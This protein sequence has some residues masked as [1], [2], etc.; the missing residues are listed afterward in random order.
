MR[1]DKSLENADA[2]AFGFDAS[3]PPSYRYR[4]QPRPEPLPARLPAEELFEIADILDRERLTPNSEPIR[5]AASQCKAGIRNDGAREYW[6]FDIADLYINL[7]NQRHLR[8]RSA[9]MDHVS[10]YYL[11]PLRN[12]FLIRR[13]PLGVATS[14]S[15]RQKLIF[16]L[17]PIM[18]LQAS[19]A[20]CERLGISIRTFM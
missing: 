16:T 5:R 18:T 2:L 12:M 4:Y 14:C 17:T 3:P 7:E 10:A 1:V 11:S 9:V 15:D 6:G 19:G 8:P 13:T 20:I